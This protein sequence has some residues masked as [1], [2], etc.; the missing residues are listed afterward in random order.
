[1]APERVDARGVVIITDA[2]EARIA[3]EV[4]GLLRRDLLWLDRRPPTSG[5]VVCSRCR[6]GHADLDGAALPDGSGT[7]C[8]IG[9][10]AP[11]AWVCAPCVV[12]LRAAGKLLARATVRHGS[13]PE[14]LQAAL[15]RGRV[16]TGN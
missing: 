8:Y 3:V 5:E 9:G 6:G 12:V 7:A 16:V 10:A 11:P 4:R 13:T 14:E 15:E 2:G 1:M